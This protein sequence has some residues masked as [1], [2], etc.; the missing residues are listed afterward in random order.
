MLKL[1]A[2]V[3]LVLA[4]RVAAAAAAT[5]AATAEDT[6]LGRADAPV[7]IIEYASLTCPHCARFH[8]ATLPRLRQ[9]WI[10]AGKA[11]L[12]FRDFPLDKLAL[13]AAMM[14]RCADKAVYFDLLGELFARQD[15]WSRADDA[16]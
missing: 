5:P 13:V 15:E 12:V 9:E 3:G 16:P 4:L 14:A 7:T 6:V 10:D 1:G 11:R 8:A 2:L